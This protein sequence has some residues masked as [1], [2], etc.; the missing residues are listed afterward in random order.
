MERDTWNDQRYNCLAL[1]ASLF[2][3]G[4]DAFGGFNAFT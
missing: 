4:T 1:T 3:L 2:H